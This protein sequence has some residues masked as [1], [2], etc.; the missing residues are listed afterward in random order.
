[1]L[2]AKVCCATTFSKSIKCPSCCGRARLVDVP[3]GVRH[4][5]CYLP[6]PQY[7]VIQDCKAAFVLVVDRSGQLWQS[8]H[9]VLERYTSDVV[10]GVDIACG[11]DHT[12]VVVKHEL[13]LEPVA[14]CALVKWHV[15][16]EQ[17]EVE[18]GEEA[19]IKGI[20]D[21]LVSDNA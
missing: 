9:V 19:I 7:P 13:I 16:L 2:R 4:L 6:V 3:E 5:H 17:P 14:Q 18:W 12:A 11:L 20:S 15:A 8:G 1:M 10:Q 21:S